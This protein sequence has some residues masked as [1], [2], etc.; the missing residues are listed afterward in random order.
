MLSYQYDEL[1][2]DHIR[3]LD[4]LPGHED[5]PL[6]CSLRT[7]ELRD[8]IRYE[9]VSYVW[10]DP[11]T[12]ANLECNESHV[13]VTV[14]LMNAL[15]RFRLPDKV[16]TLWADG[17]CINQASFHEKA[18]QVKLMGLIYWKAQ[19]VL[20]WLGNDD[21]ED[22]RLKADA[23]VDLIRATGENFKASGTE[24]IP[25][26]MLPR[27][28]SNYIQDDLDV[29]YSW[30]AVYFLFDRDWFKRVWT[31]QELGL[32]TDAV[33]YCGRASFSQREL[34][35]FISYLNTRA[36][37]LCDFY[38]FNLGHLALSK[39]YEITTRGSLR[40]EYGSDQK[41]AEN[42]LEILE[43]SQGLH[44]S[45]PRDAVYAFLGHPSA[46]KS[47][48][49]D[50]EPYMWY[51]RIYN[52]L[53]PLILPN[54]DENNDV[55]NVFLQLALSVIERYNIGP[56][57][58]S[59]IK[60]D[61]RTIEDEYP[62]WVPRWDLA[63]EHSAWRSDKGVFYSASGELPSSAFEI[64]RL[65][66]QKYGSQLRLKALGLDS[67]FIA[68]SLPPNWCFRILNNK[69]ERKDNTLNESYLNPLE[70]VHTL[71]EN[72]RPSLPR[73]YLNDEISL[74]LTLTAGLTT[75]TGLVTPAD[76]D[77]YH[78][79]ESYCSYRLQKAS[80]W[81]PNFSEDLRKH[82]E[83][84]TGDADVFAS[85]IAVA[86]ANRTFFCTERGHLGLGPRI[87][88]EHDQCWIPQGSKAPCIL[89]PIDGEKYKIIGEAYIHGLMRG[90]VVEVLSEDDFEDI[91]IC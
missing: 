91:V 70:E 60:H 81:G 83:T 65:E 36:R 51:P 69:F 39:H 1:T 3:I 90:E 87:I 62:T 73:P 37:T 35:D 56:E 84:Y 54:Y 11:K 27:I 9:A 79:F 18:E 72:I 80:V 76:E 15:R 30:L 44:C 43:R 40:I 48:L 64:T 8:T 45:D 88:R 50:V 75:T 59:H 55:K 6:R 7:V 53:Q 49:L 74:A 58:F 29:H 82:L 57:L 10:G 19:K 42:F 61:E 23:A 20:V 46:F 14:N 16:R 24:D 71:W 85:D 52:K 33:F 26:S 22:V 31:V 47:K 67:V 38:N 12:R 21:E 77:P 2:D 78:H 25:A 17:V 13:S 68:F 89:R 4:V 86:A 34:N 41:L 5:T 66:G 32:A 28:G 63:E